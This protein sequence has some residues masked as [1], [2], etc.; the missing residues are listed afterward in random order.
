[1]SD[2]LDE[3]FFADPFSSGKVRGFVIAQ[4]I[5]FTILSAFF[6]L[7]VS[8]PVFAQSA[9][10]THADIDHDAGAWGF[11]FLRAR[12][13]PGIQ[14]QLELSPR[15][16][17]DF[18]QLQSIL[19]R[20]SIIFSIT[21]QIS[22]SVGYLAQLRW[23]AEGFDSVEHRV[24][25]QVQGNFDLGPV[26]LIPRIRFE[27]RLRDADS[28]QIAHR[29]RTML[30]A[31]IPVLRDER[32]QTVIN[33]VVF[34]ELFTNLGGVSGW[35]EGGFDQNRAFLGANA[36]LGEGVVLETGYMNQ[37]INPFGD[38]ADR[39]AHLWIVNLSIDF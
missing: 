22:G 37:F 6:A 25:E 36:R 24:W 21:P 13:R 34:D 17:E 15:I 14:G 5:M 32:R 18:S 7:G 8:Q 23:D 9:M 38:G 16:G 29:L 4:R 2:V 30:R 20:P 1:M 28:S 33:I 31:Q 10:V 39:M 19:I 11:V 27:Q 3:V 26:V 12:I 35:T